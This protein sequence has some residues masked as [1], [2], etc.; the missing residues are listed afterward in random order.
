MFQDTLASAR[1][2]VGEIAFL[3]IDCDWYESTSCVLENFFPLLDSGAKIII[4]DYDYWDGIQKAYIKYC[5][6]HR[7][8]YPLVKLTPT[9][10]LILNK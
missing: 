7:L 4:D 6:R 5:T 3:P 8:H 1:E 2:K 9:T 10:A